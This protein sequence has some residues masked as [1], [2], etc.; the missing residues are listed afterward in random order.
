[1]TVYMT[2]V[3]GFSEPCGPLQ[4]STEGWRNRARETLVEGDFVV[5]VGTAQPPTPEEERG[6]ILGMME[7]STDMV[8]SLDFD[9]RRAPHDFDDEGKYRWPYSLLNRRAWIFEERP[10]LNEISDR[11]FSM[12]SVLG[13]VPL[14]SDEAARVLSLPRREARLL[15]SVRAR[16]RL[17]GEDAARRRVAPP[18]TTTRTGVM[19]LRRAP[20]Y[21]YCMQVEGA[22]RL[23]FKIGWAF[24][25][26]VRE[27]QFNQAAL[28]EIG[29]LRYRTK[30][31]HL[32][33]TAREAYSM[34]QSVLRHFDEIRHPANREILCGAVYG[35]IERAWIDKLAETT[36]T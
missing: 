35:D 25:F 30:L 21:T 32:W 20:S 24:D 23:A 5:T 10:L 1:M 7:P 4:F 26:A 34:E 3:W 2:K 29:G 22:E 33:D 13:I 31:Y 36:R 15:E 9:L 12:D 17:E 27:R 8:N 18:P 11:P 14:T 28:P 19:H 6:R 16:A